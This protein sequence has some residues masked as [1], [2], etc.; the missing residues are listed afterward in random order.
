[1]I[2]ILAI[3]SENTLIT[4][5]ELKRV[6]AAIQIQVS[7][8]L[9]PHWNVDATIIA[10]ENET[11][12]PQG[13]WRAVVK[14]TLP[15]DVY[16]Y[17]IVDER[18]LPIAYLR[19]QPN[20]TVTLSHEIIETLVNPYGNKVMSGHEFYGQPRD[21]DPTNN[22]EYLVEIADPSQTANDGYEIQ[23][24]RVSDFF[25]PAFYDLVYT[26]GKQYSF[27]GAIKRPVTLADGGYISFKRLGEWYQAFSTANGIAIKKLATGETLTT[28][29]QSRFQRAV[30]FSVGGLIVIAGIYLFIR[31][32][33]RNV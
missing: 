11:Q 26:E 17:H 7:R 10:V 29:Q 13:A 4:F 9:K 15:I 6:A 21:N 8:D 31:K 1:M 18:N 33:R 32:R 28:A 22:V 12:V 3:Y 14:N 30:L 20:W 16:G 24:V 2:P 5:E 27:T 25:L 19:W 23:G